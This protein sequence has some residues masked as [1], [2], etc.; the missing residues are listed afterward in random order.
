MICS[1]VVLHRSFP[2]DIPRSTAAVSVSSWR[3]FGGEQ[4]HDLGKRIA[5][6][7]GE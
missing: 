1:H 5:T 7:C 2:L 4:E 3:R 6:S